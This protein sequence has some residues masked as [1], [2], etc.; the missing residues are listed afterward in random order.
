[1]LGRESEPTAGGGGGEEGGG[2]EEGGAED[3]EE[4]VCASH[5]KAIHVKQ[6]ISH[7]PV[8]EARSGRSS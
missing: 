5:A 2:A 3:G 4:G 6:A 8:R 7:K 1:M